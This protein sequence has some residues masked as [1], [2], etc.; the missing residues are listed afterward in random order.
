MRQIRHLFLGIFL[1]VLL[2]C[3]AGC[4]V[5]DSEEIVKDAVLYRLDAQS[6]LEYNSVYKA[7]V[8]PDVEISGIGDLES[9]AEVMGEADA[10]PIRFGTD[11]GERTL[12]KTVIA[13]LHID[14]NG[15][16][17]AIQISSINVRPVIGITWRESSVDD[18]YLEIAEVLERNG[19]YA[20]Y[21]PQI[22][23]EEEAQKTLAEL[24]GLFML[25]GA[26]LNPALYD[27]VQTVHGSGGWSN[28]RDT[29]DLYLIQNA[30]EMDI[31]LLAICRGAQLMNV[32]LGGSL[33]QDIPYYLGQKVL[34]GEID[35]EW[36]TKVL[37]GALPNDSDAVQDRGYVYYNEA[38]EKVGRTYDADS[39]TYM[40]DSGCAEG[41][42]R[43][44]IDGVCHSDGRTYH[45]LL[46]GEGNDGVAIRSDSKW[47]YDI[48][49]VNEIGVIATAHHQAI[50]PNDLGEGLSIAAYASDGIVEAIEYTDNLFAL[51]LQWHPERS[52]LGDYGDIGIDPDVSAT[53]MRT[54]V[55][56]AKIYK[57]R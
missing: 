13:D 14:E 40:K 43:V 11:V 45:A 28:A 9:L 2:I 42:L 31:P 26:D 55:E 35:D 22:T 53:I 3:T 25:G 39:D 1:A 56:Y 48:V 54:L 4:S 41:H 10:T 34:A 46:G 17:T 50:D 47:L 6:N 18:D 27:E 37:S 30:I 44:E 29:S 7:A 20:V 32:V 12:G 57:N 8:A 15:D 49:G 51:G 38:Y 23:T 52:V 21:L 19:A 36:V 16:I 33:I 5:R 24:D